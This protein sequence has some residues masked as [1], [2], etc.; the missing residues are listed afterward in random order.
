[1]PA[2]S[3]ARTGDA[4]AG[5]ASAPAGRPRGDADP[6]RLPRAGDPAALTVLRTRGRVLAT[7]QIIARAG[8]PPEIVGYGRAKRFAARAVSLPDLAAVHAFLLEQ[9]RR[10][11]EF[12]V[13][14]ALAEGADPGRVRRT[15]HPDPDPATGEAPCFRDVPRTWAA[16]DFDSV[17][18]PFGLDP[19]REPVE[20]GMHLRDTLPEPFAD[21]GC[22]VQ[23]TSG[24]GVKPG[25]RY[26]LWFVLSRPLFGREVAAWCAG[27]GLDPATL[28][29][30]EPI[31]TARPV[32][33]G[34]PDPV[35]RRVTLLPGLEDVVQVPAALPGR[36]DRPCA[37]G[38][39]GAPAA[40]GFDGWLDLVGGG[41]GLRGFRRPML[42]A[43]CAYAA[44]HGADKLEEA[45][46]TL[47]ARIAGAFAAAPKKP[48]RGDELARY[49]ADGHFA[50]LVG[51]I[52]AR[53]RRRGQAGR[54]GAILA[55][56]LLAGRAPA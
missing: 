45:S 55:A 49:L 41:D 31:Y 19:A 40:R 9:D 37:L 30:V 46:G 23:A 38:R 44:R 21:A 32:V 54:H 10:P 2:S 25:L 27:P 39:G 17:P 48:G 20:A 43:L 36:E 6:T 26:R 34:M 35:P 13:R 28:H 33:S 1:M 14:A 11:R 18:A 52:A 50:E 16:F 3:F 5:A 12:A 56:L 24:C 51:W 29:P 15:L 8:A 47:R 53:Q 7:K 42:A 4:G 22:V